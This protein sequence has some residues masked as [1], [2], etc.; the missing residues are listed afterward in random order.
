MVYTALN[1]QNSPKQSSPTPLDHNDL[2]E[3]PFETSS[4]AMVFPGQQQHQQQHQRVR[5]PENGTRMSSR[6]TPPNPSKRMRS[7]S[8]LTNMTRQQVPVKLARNAQPHSHSESTWPHHST[9]TQQPPPLTSVAAG[10]S[11]GMLNDNHN[12]GAFEETARMLDQQL[13]AL[14]DLASSCR[15]SFNGFRQRQREETL[16]ILAR[17]RI[18]GARLGQAGAS[19][20]VDDI[21]RRAEEAVNEVK[22]Q[23][24][25]E[26]QRGVAAAEQKA[27]EMVAGERARLMREVAEARQR[28]FEEAATTFNK[29]EESSEVCFICFFYLTF[30]HSTNYLVL[31]KNCANCGR[32]ASERCSACEQVRYC[33]RFC[34]LHDWQRHRLSCRVDTK[35]ESVDITDRSSNQA[36]ADPVDH[37]ESKSSNGDDSPVAAVPTSEK[38][39][40][41]RSPNKESSPVSS[42]A[43]SSGATRSESRQSATTTAC[44]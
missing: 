26:L 7:Q 39:G 40:S 37:N 19:Q 8:P 24:C 13:A 17:E 4:N 30:C 1:S 6:S 14:G 36:E 38:K 21:R 5:T 34:Q 27:R 3:S 11:H 18:A 44:I 10:V 20:E 31:L 29:Q 33:G 23:A 25:I 22:R 28:G 43:S 42:I 41:K 16:A 35:Q 9:P 15:R 12:M 32:N 2:V